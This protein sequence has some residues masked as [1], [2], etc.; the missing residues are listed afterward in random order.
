[1]VVR[2]AVARQNCVSGRP[3][4]RRPGPE[5]GSMGDD[6][7]GDTRVEGVAPPDAGNHQ[8]P[9]GNVAASRVR[10]HPRPAR[11]GGA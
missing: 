3:R 6:V 4:K 5:T 2:G 1:M 11:R 8:P 7:V 10:P 9:E